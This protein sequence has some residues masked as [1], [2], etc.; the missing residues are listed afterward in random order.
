MLQSKVDKFVQLA[1]QSIHQEFKDLDK[2]TVDSMIEKSMI[3]DEIRRK[4]SIYM[5]MTSEQL[6][7]R[8]EDNLSYL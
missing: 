2:E 7:D 3:E 5:H 1:K 4:P 6:A 8:V